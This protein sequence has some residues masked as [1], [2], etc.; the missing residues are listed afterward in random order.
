MSVDTTFVRRFLLRTGDDM[1]ALWLCL[2]ANAKAYADAGSALVV[3]IAVYKPNRSNEQNAYMW[4]GLLT[5]ISEQVYLGGQRYD[6]EVW[7]EHFKRKYLPEVNAKGAQKWRYLPTGERMLAMGTSDLNRSEM[8][9]YLE[10]I[11]AEAVTELGVLLP[12]NP[13]D[14]P[15]GQERR[16]PPAPGRLPATRNP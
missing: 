16:L 12:A 1:R 5:P 4:A 10:Q 14:L 9:V 3:T 8:Q 2:K 11:E 13:R 6:P 7:H 15:S